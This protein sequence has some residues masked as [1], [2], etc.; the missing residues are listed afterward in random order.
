MK[1][2]VKTYK[3]IVKSMMR[4][5]NVNSDDVCEVLFYYNEPNE[6]FPLWTLNVQMHTLNRVIDRMEFL[7]EPLSSNIKT[8]YNR[9]KKGKL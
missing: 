9:L 8:T 6:N 3:K 5:F 1:K 4:E 7:L 2:T